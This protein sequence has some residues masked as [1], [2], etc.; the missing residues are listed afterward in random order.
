MNTGEFTLDQV[1]IGQ[2]VR[3]VGVSDA[4][5]A[6]GGIARRL[7]DLGVRPG[8]IV[9]CLRRAPLGDPSVFELC[10]YQLCLRRTESVRVR[11]MLSG[12]EAAASPAGKPGSA[13]D[14]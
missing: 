12:T 3:V 11:V 13:G 10:G 14:T 6:E 8:M 4:G 7:A 9:E 2:R 5:G 1:P